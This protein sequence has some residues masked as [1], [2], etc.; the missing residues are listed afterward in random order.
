MPFWRRRRDKPEPAKPAEPSATERKPVERG[1][2]HVSAGELERA[3]KMALRL[4]S[5]K[6]F[7]E[8]CQRKKLGNP[9]E[10]FMKFYEAVNQNRAFWTWEAKAE[11]AAENAGKTFSRASFWGKLF[12]GCNGDPLNAGSLLFKANQ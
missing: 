2:C 7:A 9:V 4:A 10:A 8:F 11:E 1:E 12:M 5:A 3:R 6:S